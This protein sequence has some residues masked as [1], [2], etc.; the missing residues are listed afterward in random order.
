MKRVC[1]VS[2]GT[3]GHLM[4]AV[5]LARALQR[6]GHSP[7]ILTEGRAVESELLDRCPGVEDRIP[8][9]EL[10]VGRPGLT[11]PLRL[12][13]ATAQARRY[14]REN[15][16][17]LI[18]G[19]GGRTTVPAAFAA[20]SLR[21]PVFLLEQNVVTG[22]A[23]R[24]LTPLARRVYF[25][26]PPRA[27]PSRGLVTGTPLRPTLG[28][29]GRDEARRSLGLAVDRPV[30]FVTGGSQGAR[31]L[32]E[33][34]PAALQAA[35]R[36]LQVVHLAGVGHDRVVRARYD[37]ADRVI[38]LVRALAMDMA[39]LYAAADFVICRGGGGTVAELMVAGRPAVI[40]PY[41]HH[42]DRQQWHNARVLEVAGAAILREEC[43]LEG[44]MD[45][46]RIVSEL[47]EDPARLE[48]MGR[49]AKALSPE[50]PCERILADM[51][52]L[53]ALD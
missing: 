31:F 6:S 44:P 18:V 4:P 45:L 1:L 47:L 39:S 32:N 49:Q 3:G 34:V 43:Q 8:A 36:T 29:V 23:N 33:I 37:A 17:D 38:A 21:M 40:I 50:D 2:S 20:R 48:V 25:G 41:P 19:T 9:S 22:R 5:A 11:F 13:R 27:A 53:G 26:L 16:I 7:T 15:E 52:N 30:V 51:K 24:L 35:D 28:R 12:A 42:R 46:A 14:F 10:R